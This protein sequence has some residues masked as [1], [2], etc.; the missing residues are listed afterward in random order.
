MSD[1]R[2]RKVSLT[3]STRVGQQMIRDAADTVKKVSM[4]LGGNAP[5]IIYDDANL[6][7]AL[8]ACIPSKFGNAGQVC[9]TPDRFFVHNSLHD[10]F[11]SEFA[12]RAATLILGDGLNN[13]T[14]MGPLISSGRMG[15]VDAIVQ[16]AISAGAK[17]EVGGKP[18][19]QFKTGHFMSPL[20]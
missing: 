2:V 1:P 12:K 20:Y 18:A 5:C 14:E 16:E 11:V 13:N 4:E 3:G 10:E 15:E 9:V 8:D 7:A 6:E 17:L 19:A